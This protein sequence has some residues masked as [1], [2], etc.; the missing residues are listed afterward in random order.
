[1]LRLRTTGPF[2]APVAQLIEHILKIVGL[3]SGDVLE[4]LW[5]F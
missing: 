2:G 5:V 1:M 3:I 4:T